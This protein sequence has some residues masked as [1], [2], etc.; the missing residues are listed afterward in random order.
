MKTIFLLILIM[1]LF[2]NAQERV[3][4]VQPKIIGNINSLTK[5]TGWM[6]NDLGKWVKGNNA[7][8]NY[9]HTL[10]GVLQYCEEVIKIELTKIRYSSLDYYCFAKFIKSS[11]E[12]G[13]KVITEYSC[14][15]WLFDSTKTNS[16]FYADSTVSL[17][18]YNT[19]IP[20]DHLIN[21]KL[22]SWSDILKNIKKKFVEKREIE[23]SFILQYRFYNKNN[24]IQFIPGGSNCS[25]GESNGFYYYFEV[26]INSFKKAFPFFFK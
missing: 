3:D 2:S 18:T 13:A 6:K 12:R 15:Y 21:Y 16:T 7:I 23:N 25:T 26:D 8:P 1:P 14:D 5:F 22:I 24:S 19:V 9:D 20:T 17:N 10:H 4:E 11:Y